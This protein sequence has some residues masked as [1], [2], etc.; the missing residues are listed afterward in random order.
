[1]STNVVTVDIDATMQHAINLT[2]DHS[3]K[4]LPVL[5]QR[6]LVGIVTDR[7][8]RRASPADNVLLD[9]RQ[10]M[11][12]LSRVQ[13]RTIM[14]RDPI[15]VPPDFTVEETAEVLLKHDISGCPVVDESGGLVGII[16]KNDLFKAV[17]SLTGL[18]K[19]GIQFGFV[20][21]DRQGSIKDVTDVIRS[22]GGRLVSVLSTR[23]G[24]PDGQ[25]YVYVRAFQIDRSELTKILEECK[26]KARLLYMVDHRENKRRI[27]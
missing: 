9:I 14:T 24:A 6:R 15:T 17:I 19:R 21:E 22:H 5:E 26:H 4:I 7:D 20:L 1:M 3:V 12:H 11:H 8:L 23:E 16:T 2:M 27:F 13:V 25:R 10:I 18:S